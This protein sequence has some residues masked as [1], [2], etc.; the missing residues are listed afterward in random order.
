MVES[1]KVRRQRGTCGAGISRLSRLVLVGSG[2]GVGGGALFSSLSSSSLLTLPTD[3]LAPGLGSIWPQWAIR[4][5][6]CQRR[7]PPTRR[8]CTQTMHNGHIRLTR[9]LHIQHQ[10]VP[11][12]VECIRCTEIQ[13]PLRRFSLLASLCRR[14]RPIPATTKHFLH[15]S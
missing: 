7:I 6:G 5:T 10:T 4:R 12:S 14:H 13:E 2:L 15:Q 3:E 11:G 1:E 8:S 9:Q